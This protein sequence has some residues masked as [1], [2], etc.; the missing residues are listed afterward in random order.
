MIAPSGRRFTRRW[1]HR[2]VAAASIAIGM[3][4][5]ETWY[6]HAYRKASR[7]SARGRSLAIR[8]SATIMNARE[9]AGT[10]AQLR[11]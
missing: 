1:V 9:A 11:R 8:C 4:R 10:R 7:P 5:I 3:S 2:S 6:I